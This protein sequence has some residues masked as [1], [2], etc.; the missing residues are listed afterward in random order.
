MLRLDEFMR[1]FEIFFIRVMIGS[2]GNEW[3]KIERKMR[4]TIG[5]RGNE[6]RVMMGSSHKTLR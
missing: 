3:R 2:S 6:W 5:N 1:N 4:I